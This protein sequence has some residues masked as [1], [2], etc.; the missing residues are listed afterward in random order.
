MNK[1]SEPSRILIVD[2]MPINLELMKSISFRQRIHDCH[3]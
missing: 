1:T 2:D 3:F